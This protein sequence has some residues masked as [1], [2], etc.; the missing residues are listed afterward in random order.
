MLA[1]AASRR[2]LAPLHAPRS[3]ILTATGLLVAAGIGAFWFLGERQP[4]TPVAQSLPP[5][6]RSSAPATAQ[7]S[8]PARAVWP[9]SSTP[10]AVQ[11][12][13]EVAW[14]EEEKE[15]IRIRAQNEPGV[16]AAWAATLPVSNNRRF[17]LETAALA[18]GD[19][20]PAAAARWARTLANDADRASA[21]TDIA[22]EAVRSEPQFALELARSLPEAARDE[23]VPRATM[24]WAAH[25]PATAADWA[26]RITGESLRAK[27]LAGIATVW[28]DQDPV[29]GANLAAKELPAGR[30]QAD[31]VVSIVQRW[32]QRSPADAAGWVLQFPEGDL[33]DTAM[34]TLVRYTPESP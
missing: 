25:D 11:A 12:A 3:R 20:D 30:L 15:A 19:S 7:A 5:A 8:V 22:G 9:S 28:S 27:V 13:E 31:A 21:L 24:E 10:A 26:R 1:L 16:F 34:D 23:L 6:T 4:V 17:A 2:N 33:R 14:S 32:A 29:G 18:W